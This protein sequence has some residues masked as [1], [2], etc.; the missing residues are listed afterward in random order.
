MIGKDS[1]KETH[2][3][4]EE[5]PQS[6]GLFVATTRDVTVSVESFFLAEQSEP[7][8]SHYVWAYHVEVEN[9]GTETLQLTHRHW[10]ITDGA[11]NTQE[12]SGEGVVG[13]QPMLEPGSS[14]DY[15]S[16]TPLSTPSGIMVG[17]YEMVSGTGETLSVD[18]PAF[19][20]DSPYEVHHLH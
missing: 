11:G 9:N 2:P 7:T 10:K 6:S 4:A 20:L 14:F 16:G 8:Q 15:T 12:V 13:E 18:I 3:P 1:M 17:T 19:S 5:N